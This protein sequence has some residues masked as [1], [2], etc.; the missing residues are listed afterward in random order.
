MLLPAK[1]L[2]CNGLV[3]GYSQFL[4][5]IFLN[6]G[7]TERKIYPTHNLD[8]LILAIEREHIEDFMDDLNIFLMR[9]GLSRL[10]YFASVFTFQILF[11]Y[12]GIHA[13]TVFMDLLKLVKHFIYH[14][15]VVMNEYFEDEFISEFGKPS[16][17]SFMVSLF[18]L[19]MSDARLQ[20]IFM[21]PAGFHDNNIWYMRA[22]YYDILCSLFYGNY[23]NVDQRL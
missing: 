10:D 20:A 22:T 23:A 8:A 16:L 6:D 14:V 12:S 5:N 15:E 9:Y 11:T 1:F 17:I 3:K 13:R 21:W 4:S 19:C 7:F 18:T 2:K